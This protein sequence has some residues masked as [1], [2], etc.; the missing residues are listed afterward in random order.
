MRGRPFHAGRP[1]CTGRRSGRSRGQPCALHDA[2]DL[3]ELTADFHNDG[4]RRALHSAHGERGEDEGQHC[5]DEHTDQ[6]S[7]AGQ[8]EVEGLGG[9]VPA[10]C[11]HRRPAGPGRSGR[12]SRWRSPCRWRRWCCPGSPGRPCARA[13]PLGQTGHLGDTAGVVG[14]GAISVGRESDAERGKHAYTGDADA[15][16]ALVEGLGEHTVGVHDGDGAAGGE[17]AHQH[18]H[19][20]DEDGSQGRLQPQRDTADDD[21]GR[22]GLRG[23]G[24]FLRGR[25]SIGGVVF[26][27]IADGATPNQAAAEDGH[28]NAPLVLSQDQVAQHGGHD[29]GEHGGGVGAGAQ[30]LQQSGLGGVSPWCGRRRC[31]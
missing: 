13:P 22:A 17:I 30:A 23:V 29:G 15:V 9:V 1:G 5:A 12:Q 8:G 10:R 28:E 27:E 24:Q 25:I 31:R 7:G 20:Y 14:Y 6:N 18:G 19:G 3:L 26:S 2:G 21:G 4:L 16:E 11:S